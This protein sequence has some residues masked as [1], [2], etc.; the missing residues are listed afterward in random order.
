M[1]CWGVHER[2]SIVAIVSVQINDEWAFMAS[3]VDGFNE[4]STKAV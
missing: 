1:H 4:K 3:D 2:N